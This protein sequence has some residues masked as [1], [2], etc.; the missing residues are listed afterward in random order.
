MDRNPLKDGDE[1]ICGGDYGT[2]VQRSQYQLFVKTVELT[3]IGALYGKTALLEAMPPFLGG[4]D[5]IKVVKL[6]SFK[7]NSLPYKFEAGTPAIAETAGFG[8]AVDYLTKVGMHNVA[9][10]E[11]EITEYA[12]ERLEEIPGLTL[13]GPSADKKGGVA[14]F[15]LDN[16][17][18][19]DVAQI[20]DGDGIAV[21]AGHH[22]AQPIMTRLGITATARAI[23]GSITPQTPGRRRLSLSTFHWLTLHIYP[24]YHCRVPRSAGRTV[25]TRRSC[26]R[27]RAVEVRRR[28]ADIDREPARR[29]V[30]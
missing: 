10:H 26:G 22:C 28:P 5:M 25:V 29:L 15:T 1:I 17:H 12:L 6:R 13:M 7:P 4:G 16:V 30:V 14:A 27:R 9:A 11:H 19:H 24:M 8:A 23:C 20:L 3:G 2:F 21:R 18:P